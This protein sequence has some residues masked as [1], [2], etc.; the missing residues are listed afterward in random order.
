MITNDDKIALGLFTVA[1]VLF[2][3][4]GFIIGH[5]VIKYLGG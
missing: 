3:A 4:S 5:L 2:L 1:A